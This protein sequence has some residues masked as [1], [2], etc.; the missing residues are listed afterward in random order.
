MAAG[1]GSR[2]G[3]LKQMDP[4][5]R[6]GHFIMDFS[7]FD[8]REAGFE[9]VVFII[10]KELEK[11]F[12]ERIVS[13]VSRTMETECVFQRLDDIPEGFTVPEGRVKPWGTGHAL[14]SCRDAVKGPFVAINADDYYGR[15][16][17]RDLYR[18]LSVE[19]GCGGSAD[20]VTRAATPARFA[21]SG[22]RLENT[23]TENGHVARGICS[24]D[25]EGFL[26]DIVERTRIEVRDGRPAFSEDDGA[27]WTTF[28]DGTV[29][30]MNMW[31][32]TR[33]FLDEAVEKFPVFLEDALKNNPQKGEFFIPSI[34][35]GMLREGRATVKVLPTPDKWYGVTYSADK[36]GV[37]EAIARMKSE[38]LYPEDF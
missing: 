20:S 30:S 19:N 4:V 3:G 33:A 31:G 36:A 38:G 35:D 27:T 5:D 2:Y 9:K 16:A 17:F 21:M 1:M 37:V 10:K 18:H 28:P 26:T 34:V 29:V 11:D 23:V 6:E 25:S 14:Y 12:N 7:I 22:Y 24:T 32:F 8:A 15:Q 13:R